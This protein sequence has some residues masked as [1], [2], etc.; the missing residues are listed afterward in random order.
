[1][2]IYRIATAADAD[3]LAQ[4]RWDFLQV[5]HNAADSTLDF[6]LHHTTIFGI[7]DLEIDNHPAGGLEGRRP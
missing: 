4:M 3:E 2:M 5:R 6:A 7:R 1:M